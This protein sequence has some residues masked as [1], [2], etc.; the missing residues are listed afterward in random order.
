MFK[1]FKLKNTQ[2]TIS[3]SKSSI[4]S[5]GNILFLNDSNTHFLLNNA[6]VLGFYAI[7]FFIFYYLKN[8]T[9]ELSENYVKLFNISMTAI[10]VTLFLSNKYNLTRKHYIREIF[11]KLYISLILTLGMITLLVYYLDVLNISR[12]FVISFVL[13]GFMLEII[14]FY[15]ISEGR[16]NI[17][18]GQKIK[19]SF[20][21]LIADAAILSIVVYL[22]IIKTIGLENLNKKKL[23]M[24]IIVYFSW[25]FFAAITH[26]FDPIGNSKS[27]LTA[28]GLHIKYYLLVV[29]FI[30]FTVFSLGIRDTHWHYFM[31]AAFT[32]SIASFILFIFLFFDRIEAK[33]DEIT[34]VFLKTFEVKGP[35]NAPVVK[36]TNEKYSFSNLEVVGSLLKN[37]LESELLKNYKNVFDF[38]NRN[39]SLVT[40]DNRKTFLVKSAD[41]FNMQVL[42]NNSFQ[43]IINLHELNDFRRINDYL[44]TINNKLLKGGVFVSSIIPN[45]NRHIRYSS[46]YHSVLADILYF[47]DF[48]WKRV[49]PKIPLLRR[50]YFLIEKGTD[51]AISLAE[52]L[53]RLVFTG[54][55]I[56][57]LQEID[58]AV[59]FIAVKARDVSSDKDPEYSPIFRMKR[60]GK[61]GK[62]IFV[63]KLRTMHPYSEYIQDFVYKQNSLGDGG[64]FKDDFRIP[65]W[66]KFL[67]KFWIDELPMLANWIKGDLKFVGVRPISNH[68]LGLY[69]VEHQQRRRGFKPGLVPP[70]YADM[71]KSIEEIEK[72]ER[73][74]LESYEKHPI[75]TDVKYFFKI[76]HNILFMKKRSA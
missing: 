24:L 50:I 75:I 17:N 40:F 68:Y 45:K 67:R 38:L 21:Y 51:R 64:K 46:K 3:D 4:E 25:F 15:A 39:I 65:G 53:G 76:L 42:N 47:F 14:Y 55:E 69:S 27:R 62:T 36:N 52:G 5:S 44:R 2:E 20:A 59:Y 29:S 6:L 23:L 32:Y 72:S 66:G 12:T 41:P 58:S 49:I 74:Y 35:A 7:S 54:F 31:Q 19:I 28:I 34:S 48:L 43:M 63:Y 30:S 9:L 37:K 70:F 16:K 60:V 33:T 22:E 56:L 8:S 13:T 57:D 73:D 61:N 18:L 10:L 11:R 26:K 1:S 71:P